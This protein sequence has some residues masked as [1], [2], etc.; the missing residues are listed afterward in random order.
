MALHPV[1]EAALATAQGQVPYY[2]LPLDQARAKA[3]SAYPPIE[4]PVQVAAVKN[5]VTTGTSH[6]IPLRVYAPPGDGPHPVLVFFHGSGFVLLDL[7]THDD[8]CR[9]LCVGARCLLLS[10]FVLFSFAPFHF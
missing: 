4:V 1:I 10:F 6:P 9:R 3:R 7:D 5:I 2:A 8:I